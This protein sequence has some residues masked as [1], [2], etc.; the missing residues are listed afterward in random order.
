LFV[1]L[2]HKAEKFMDIF[3]TVYT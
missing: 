1:A 3:Y 2:H